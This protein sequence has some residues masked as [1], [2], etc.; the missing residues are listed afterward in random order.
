MN[1]RNITRQ[2][3][4]L[5]F[6][7]CQLLLSVVLTA[8]SSDNDSSTPAPVETAI[9]ETLNVDVIMP[10]EVRSM[11]QSA[12][13]LA[14]ANIEAAQKN[15]DLEQTVYSLCYP[16]EGDDTCHLILG[17]YRSSMAEMVL[18]NA[19]QRRVPVMMPDVTSDEVQRIMDNKP[20]AWFM[21]ESDVT[22]CE[23]FMNLGSSN[24]IRNAALIYS[25]DRYGNS[26]R[27]W[28]G[29]MATEF[30]I[31]VSPNF[32]RSYISGQDMTDIFEQ[33]EKAAADKGESSMVLIAVSSDNDY[34]QLIKQVVAARDRMDILDPW[35]SPVTYFVSDVGDSPAV[36]SA[37]L[38]LYG[39][40]PAAATMS[41]FDTYYY[42]LYK[43]NAPNG[44]AQ[45]Y[46]ALMIAALGAAKR[47][48]NPSGPDQLILDGEKVEYRDE[49]YG[50]NLSDWMRALVADKSG[51]VSTD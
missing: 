45:V 35:A 48:G 17:P 49:P 42:S 44:A 18:A 9:V 41:G 14:I 25:N 3:I 51:T 37:G 43:E 4:C 2:L 23:A 46:D 12:I 24:S 27:N 19:A 36:Y 38:P 7:V 22:A 30:G 28:F 29:Y 34:K 40:S 31:T 5:S 10:V 21:T 13:D 26:F 1:K 39:L 16:K 33:I 8:C 20:Y 50:P 11:W 15:L 47:A 32:L 6:I